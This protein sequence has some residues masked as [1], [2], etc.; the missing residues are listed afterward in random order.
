MN[1]ISLVTLRLNRPGVEWHPQRLGCYASG[2]P[3]HIRKLA[4]LAA[5]AL[6]AGN[7]LAQQ[8]PLTCPPVTDRPCDTF[9]YH[10][11]M[12]RPDTKQLVEVH[13]TA[14]FATQA[15][16][17]RAR[18]A[19]SKR[20]A[21]IVEYFR[22]T[23]GETRYEADRIGACHCD[24]TTEAQKAKQVLTA[25]EIKLRV[26][27]RLLDA[28]LTTDAELVRSLW[29][30][31]P[32]TA[33][34]GGARLVPLPQVA[35]QPLLV[36]AEDLKATKPIDT[37]KT[38]TVQLDLPLAEFGAAPALAP[39]PDAA[40]R[41]EA[42]IAGEIE[43]IQ[44]ILKASASISDEEV[45][46]KI[47]DASM[48]RIQLL[49]NLRH[50]I[51]AAGTRSRIAAAAG[52]TQDEASRLALVT[53]LFGEE[54]VSHWAPREAFD[55]IFN[56]P[57][58]VAADPERAL[59]DT[60]GQFTDA[61][62]RI[63]LYLVLAQTQPTEE[64]RLWLTS[65][66]D[67]LLVEEAPSDEATKAFFFAR[68]F[69][70]LGEYGSAYDQLAKADTLRPDQPALLYDMALTLAKAGRW[71]EAQVKLDRYQQLHPNGEEKALV[72][73][74]QL[75][76]EFQRE[77]QKKRQAEQ[78]Y[79]DL[80]N[81]AKYVYASGALD[82]ALK[83]FVQAEQLRPA[84]A[85]AIFNQA[86]IHEKQGD[87]AKAVARFRRSNELEADTAIDPRVF[88]LEHELADMQT[89][90]VCPF[91]GHKL[92]IGTTWCHRCWHG[93]YFTSAALWNTRACGGPTATRATWYAGDR[94]AKN[95]ELACIVPEKS[96][97]EAL[98]YSP[99]KQRSIQEARKA[100]GWLYASGGVLQAWRDQIRFV[101]GAD[102]LERVTAANG[103]ILEYA[104]HAGGEG[105]WL[106]DR[107]DLVIDALRY[108]NRYTFDE[109]G[110]I[111]VQQV[112]YVNTAACNHVVTMTADYA[113][114][115]DALI[116]VK[117][118]GGY[119][120]YPAEGAPETKWQATIA[121][122]Y[123]AERRVTKEE[124]ALTQIAKTYMQRPAGALRDDIER[125]YPGLRA[126][127]AL[128]TI[129]RVGDVCATAGNTLLMNP[130]DLR[131]FYT[132]SPNLGFALPQGVNRA[133]VTFTY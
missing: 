133:A 48:Q 28:G 16:C 120:G 15:A 123:D 101:Q 108:T 94:P 76:L 79:L 5:L 126:K 39:P 45:K 91:C 111:D 17:E 10:V 121:Y 73:K 100:E 8:Q 90:I 33:L 44:T 58:A 124:L 129:L 50:V 130:I 67:G 114:A 86:V 78:E 18:E 25:E 23:K 117:I 80:F 66:V 6:A 13:G 74:L 83:L 19:E 93:P 82:D 32:V 29:A 116:S 107:E 9:H 118:D 110:R 115:N 27:E 51:E 56:A 53:R 70:D 128:E 63:A 4:L 69:F 24:A 125:V 20:N 64:S 22:K 89:K 87:F 112:S 40:Q 119:V 68:K 85:A 75:E 30:E 106:L 42:F 49:G 72:A 105:I 97:L 61:Q 26:R 54:V 99:A 98:R 88:A 7:A 36:S 71:S 1:M 60:T 103:D 122:T 77:L 31:A 84:D 95:E 37:S 21:A 81:R 2:G 41:A 46:S 55:V 3:M 47:F 57:P 35:A 127:R 92:P 34:L 43:R 109:K 11:Q 38:I 104:A 52:A 59:R 12:F 132:V 131:P 14:V 62:K 113:Y 96:L 65:V 102:Y